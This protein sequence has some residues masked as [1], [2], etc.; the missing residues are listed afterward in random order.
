VSI[1]LLQ[2]ITTTSQVAG[3]KRRHRFKVWHSTA[4]EVKPLLMQA[5]SISNTE[6]KHA[7][8]KA[9]GKIFQTHPT[10]KVDHTALLVNETIQSFFCLKSKQR[11]VAH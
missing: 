9:L 3:K 2:I 11:L 4:V 7:S 5:S 8:P 10:F 6:L 1:P